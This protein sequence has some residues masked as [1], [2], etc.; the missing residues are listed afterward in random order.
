MPPDKRAATIAKAVRAAKKTENVPFW[1][2]CCDAGG[3]GSARAPVYRADD[4]RLGALKAN[5]V[6]RHGL[7]ADYFLDNQETPEGR[8]Y[9]TASSRSFRTGRG[10]DQG[11]AFPRRPAVEPLLVTAGVWW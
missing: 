8:R 6:S 10:P 5:Y 1:G 3:L 7:G 2:K 11:C 9:C 4:G